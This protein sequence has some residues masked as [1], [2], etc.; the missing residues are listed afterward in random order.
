MS[1]ELGGQNSAAVVTEW[2]DVGLV[3][4]VLEQPLRPRSGVDRRQRVLRT[5]LYSLVM[6]R[7]RGERRR[8]VLPAVAYV[9][10][11]EPLLLFLSLGIVAMS[12]M[13]AFLTLS[14]LHLGAE[15]ANPFMAL[16]LEHSVTMFL[17]VKYAATALGVV[18]LVMHKRYTVLRI[19][20]GYRL[21]G[22]VFVMYVGLM[23]YEVSMLLST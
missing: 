16:L 9:D 21:L 13:D 11:H 5:A 18:S 15:E 6:G 22:A 19:F 2:D 12:V 3:D 20:D 10:V 23:C 8:G 7:R 17:A 4:E 1:S 14:L